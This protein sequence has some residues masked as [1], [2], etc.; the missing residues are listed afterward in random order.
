MLEKKAIIAIGLAAIIIAAAGVWFMAGHE[1]SEETEGKTV[2]DMLGRE[3]AVPE[4]VDKIVCLSAGTV[5]LACYLGVYDRIVGIDS[6]DAGS[7]GMPANYE[8]ATYRIA[9]DIRSIANVGAEDN[10][11][12]IIETGADVIFTSTTDSSIADVLQSNTSIP[13]VAV[14]AAG[15]IDLDDEKF[16]SNIELMSEVL[17]VDQRAKQLIE[18]KNALLSELDGLRKASDSD[19]RCYIGGMFYF[20]QGGFLRTTGNY[21]P[22][23]YAG[24]TNV[25]KDVN[26]G[27]PYDTSP[28]EIAESGAEYMFIDVMTYSQSK[29]AFAENEEILQDVPAVKEGNIYATMV[30]K[31]YGTNWESELINAYYIGSILD[32]A[33]F[34]FDL[35]QKVDSVLDLFF[36]DSDIDY[37]KLVHCQSHSFEK[38]SW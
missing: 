16:D 10:Y 17:G 4:N 21:A 18:G 3:V 26:G 7:K 13:V 30:Y 38:Q 28:K 24:G 6:Y 5:R 33:T 29:S 11:R 23:D 27:N 34:D 14:T 37:E 8:M 15:N 25:M 36:P 22:L 9:Y 32:P 1:D 12:D 35:K 19:K 31:Y 2:T 20:M